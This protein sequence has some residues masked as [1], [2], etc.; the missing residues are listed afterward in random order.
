MIGKILMWF[1]KPTVNKKLIENMNKY[2]FNSKN[3]K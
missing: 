1:I 3:N 2:E